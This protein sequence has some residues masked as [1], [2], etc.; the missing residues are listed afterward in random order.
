MALPGTDSIC[1]ISDDASRKGKRRKKEKEDASTSIYNSVETRVGC[2]HTMTWKGTRGR[3][4]ARMKRVVDSAKRTQKTVSGLYGTSENRGREFRLLD[5]D[6]RVRMKCMCVCM[7]AREIDNGPNSPLFP[8][9][10]LTDFQAGKL[11]MK[12]KD[13][14][15]I[16]RHRDFYRG[17]FL[18]VLCGDGTEGLCTTQN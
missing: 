2:R 10:G 6:A 11:G 3:N 1:A 5:E 4:I 12:L 17:L 7:C 14:G 16:G 8:R 13:C 9:M 15:I 18:F